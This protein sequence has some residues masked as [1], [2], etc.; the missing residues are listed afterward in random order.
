MLRT[1]CESQRL[2][3]GSAHA[4]ISSDSS[5]SSQHF[6]TEARPAL[7]CRSCAGVLP[8]SHTDPP[9]ASGSVEF[10]SY[11]ERIDPS[12]FKESEDRVSLV[13]SPTPWIRGAGRKLRMLMASVILFGFVGIVLLAALLMVGIEV[14]SEVVRDSKRDPGLKIA[15]WGIAAA[16]GLYLVGRLGRFVFWLFG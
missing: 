7:D 1:L 4:Q 8:I 2:V 10:Q 3:N 9:D 12:G 6:L 15:L 14:G 16:A 5:A 13:P 11:P